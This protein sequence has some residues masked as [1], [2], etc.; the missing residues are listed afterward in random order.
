MYQNGGI[1]SC[2]DNE[3][4]K[5]HLIRCPDNKGVK[6]ELWLDVPIIRGK[7]VILATCPDNVGVNS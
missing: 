5:H 1:M 7:N 4:Q 6:I 3:G 2:P